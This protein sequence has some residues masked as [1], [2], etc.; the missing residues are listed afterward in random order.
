MNYI[1]NNIRD[2]LLK[3]FRFLNLDPL[4]VENIELLNSIE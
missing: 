3:V 1:F 2:L 4:D